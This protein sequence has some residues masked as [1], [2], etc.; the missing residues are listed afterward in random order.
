MPPMVPLA[1]AT[2]MRTGALSFQLSASRP[3]RKSTAYATHPIDISRD[4]ALM[5]S[6]VLYSEMC[7]LLVWMNYSLPHPLM[8][9]LKIRVE[10]KL[11]K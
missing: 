9:S 11:V 3:G 2:A 7:T 1:V 6:Q 10:A 8:D 5:R 4:T